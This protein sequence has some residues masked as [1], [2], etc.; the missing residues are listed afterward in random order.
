[1][2]ENHDI[3]K[4][5]VLDDE[6]FFIGTI[7]I[8]IKEK[9]DFKYTEIK[10]KNGLI[11]PKFNGKEWIEGA[12]KEKVMMSMLVPDFN[13]DI[14]SKDYL[15]L[16]ILSILKKGGM[17]MDN[18]WFFQYCMFCWAERRIEENYLE[19]AKKLKMLTDEQITMIKM[20][21]RVKLDEDE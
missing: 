5:F 1:M 17:I 18:K 6:G 12:N 7:T 21:P 15:I 2:V 9:Q 20:T 4:V 14:D 16:K 13:I 3:K 19:M 8:N 10:P 11:K